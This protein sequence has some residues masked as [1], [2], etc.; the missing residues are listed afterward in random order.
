LNGS[1]HDDALHAREANI[2]GFITDCR[3]CSEAHHAENQAEAPLHDRPRFDRC[4]AEV[5]DKWYGVCPHIKVS[6]HGV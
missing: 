3:R 2:S 1:V 5:R 4:G 6:N